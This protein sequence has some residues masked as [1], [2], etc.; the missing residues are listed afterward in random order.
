MN[1]VDHYEYCVSYESIDGSIRYR[2]GFETEKQARS[3][4]MKEHLSNFTVRRRAIGPWLPIL[5][6]DENSI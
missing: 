3:W 6:S 5:H 4:C 2:Y 1:E